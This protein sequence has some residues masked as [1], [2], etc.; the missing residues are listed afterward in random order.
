M[1]VVLTIRM[2]RSEHEGLESRNGRQNQDGS[3]ASISQPFGFAKS[4]TCRDQDIVQDLY[5]CISS[6]I[7]PDPL[8]TGM[9]GWGSTNTRSCAIVG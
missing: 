5:S 8:N 3:Q 4:Y 7:G 1:A 2:R 9:L 6:L